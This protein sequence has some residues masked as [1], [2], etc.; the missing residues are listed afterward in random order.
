M[1]KYIVS[2][3]AILALCVSLCV[4]APDADAATVAGGDC[5]ENLTWSLDDQGT[6]TISGTGAMTDWDYDGSPWYPIRWSIKKVVI[7]DS[8]TYIGSQA[9]HDCINLSSVTIPDSVIMIGGRAFENT[10]WYANQPYGLVYAG[11]VAY[12]YKGTCPASYTAGT[13]LLCPS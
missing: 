1:K 10:A 7:S 9:F 12:Q 6:L 2:L 8:V 13:A 3:L 11:K 4:M 5:G